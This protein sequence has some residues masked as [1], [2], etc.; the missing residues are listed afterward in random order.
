MEKQ[1][2]MK[3]VP[4]NEVASKSN[5]KSWFIKGGIVALALLL[6]SG[7]YY[8]YLYASTPSHLRNPEFE[9][10]HFR[11]QI[12]VDGT[13]VD[14]S[15]EEF[16]QDTP[17][18]C[19]VE[20]SGTPIDFHDNTNQ[21]THIHWDGITGGEFL[22]YYG[23]NFI[24]GSDD[25]LGRRHDEGFMRMHSVE[26]FGNLL[27]DISEGSNFYVYTGDAD[28]YEQKNWDDFLSQDLEVFFGKNSSLSKD[29]QASLLEKIFFPKAYAHGSEVDEHIVESDKTEEELT[30]INNLIGNV[31]IFVQD[32]EPTEQQIQERFANLVPLSDSVC[33]G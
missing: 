26:R 16:Q 2:T 11:T 28:G 6:F 30:R 22:K 33:G 20:V 14:F 1:E 15:E 24:G 17:G 7:G 4:E 18:T 3:D 10:Y 29:E 21:M 31:V 19:S 12:I 9:H 27:P 32:T 5:K 25:S 8:G 13:S 23:W